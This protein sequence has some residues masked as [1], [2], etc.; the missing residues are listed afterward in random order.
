RG[1]CG[2]PAWS[3]DGERIVCSGTDG[4]I[5]SSARNIHVWAFP[6]AGGAGRELLEGS[7]RTVGSS[8]ISDMRAQAQTLAPATHDGRILFLGSDQG[9]AN[10]YSCA[11]AG[12]D[13]RA[14][15]IGAHQVVS[16]SLDQDHRRLAAVVATETDPGNVVVGEIG[17]AMRK[18]SCL[19]DELLGSRY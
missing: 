4:A 15:S 18:I 8:V 19:N 9:T 10:A 12:G 14:E 13:V 17:G 2:S 7:D 1:T 6:R 11:A 3:P 5:G 16:W